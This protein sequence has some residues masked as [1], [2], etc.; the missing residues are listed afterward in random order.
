MVLIFSF[1]DGL[2]A[3]TLPGRYEDMNRRGDGPDQF[4]KVIHLMLV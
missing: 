1:F 3:D 4:Q 2:G